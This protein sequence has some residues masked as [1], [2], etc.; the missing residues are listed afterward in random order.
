[1]RALTFLLLSALPILAAIT[2]GPTVTATQSG[3]ADITTGAINC[4]GA[5]LAVVAIAYNPPYPGWVPT[6][7]T[8]SPSSTWTPLTTQVGSPGS[9]S[10]VTYYAQN[11]TTSGSMT[12]TVTSGGYDGSM[13][14]VAQCFSG[15]AASAFASSNGGGNATGGASQTFQPGSVTAC[16]GC[17]VVS[18]YVPALTSIVTVSVDSGF[19]TPVTAA[20]SSFDQTSIAYLITS[21]SG[22]VNPTW[23]NSAY[24]YNVSGTNAVFSPTVSAIP[25]RHRVIQ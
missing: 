15:A 9:R 14:V 21:S 4:T 5:N 11:A 22:T 19:S 7:V 24:Q 10:S 3:T 17:L 8:S 6:S 18:S 23:S 12:F 1:M 25:V 20:F 13:S 2:A 16:S